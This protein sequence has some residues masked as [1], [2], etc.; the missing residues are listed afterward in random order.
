[1]VLGVAVNRS[2][3]W[4]SLKLLVVENGGSGRVTAVQVMNLQHW[5]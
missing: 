3:L 1:M 5:D 2:K 4:N